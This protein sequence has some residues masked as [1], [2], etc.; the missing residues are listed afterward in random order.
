[1]TIAIALG[2]AMVAGAAVWL[3]SRPV[4][5]TR[6]VVR[7]QATLPAATPLAIDQ[8]TRDLALSPDGTR[9]AYVAGAQTQLYLR[10]LDQSDATPLAG[11]VGVRGP[12][13]SPDSEWIGF[14]QQG[15]L[16]KVS[17][18]GGPAAT[19]CQNCA[20]G[21]RGATWGPDDA[22]IF[23][24]TGGSSGLLQASAS[25]G[26]VVTLAKPDAQKGEQGYAWPEYLPGGQAVLF[27]IL[28]TGS[29]ETALVAVHDL[30]TGARHT[31]V[32]GGTHAQFV[33]PGYLVYAIAGTLRA[34]AFNRDSLAVAGNAIPVL[35]HVLTKATGGADFS[36]SPDGSLAYV[37]GEAESA[38]TLAWT[39]RQGHEEPVGVPPR[40]Y[41]VPRLSPDGQRIALDV[42]D[43]ENDIWIWDLA[44]RVLTRLTFDRAPDQYPVWTPDSRR[45]AF[46]SFR[47]GGQQNLYVHP[48]TA[49]VAS[50]GSPRV[51]TASFRLPSHPTEGRC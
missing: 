23:S 46:A 51:R 38:Q 11:I 42:R 19:I 26:Q 49:L 2:A 10:A 14:F 40:A 30:K 4:P 41:V 28:S 15:D 45:I 7:L 21:N 8:F 16:K 32:R 44:R 29:I 27:T 3:L 36:V 33:A 9:L 22:I 48:Q 17:V 13:F 43:Q 34:V 5:V 18:R 31:L 50:N 1:M 35:E 47:A 24:N 6:S 39:D 25:G 37:S 12:F 20:A